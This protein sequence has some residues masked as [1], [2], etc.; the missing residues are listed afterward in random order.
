MDVAEALVGDV[1]VN[2]RGGDV[3]VSQ[4]FLDASQVNA[5]GQQICGIGMAERVRGSKDGDS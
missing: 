4:K 5:L 1:R 3:F 2:L